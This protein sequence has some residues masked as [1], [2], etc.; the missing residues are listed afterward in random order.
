[1][2]TLDPTRVLNDVSQASVVL[3]ANDKGVKT[4]ALFIK[5]TAKINVE[6][7]LKVTKRAYK[8]PAA[9][10]VKVT[11]ATTDWVAGAYRINIDFKLSSECQRSD[12]ARFKTTKGKTVSIEAFVSV[13]GTLTPIVTSVNNFFKPYEN[14]DFSVASAVE[15]TNTVL[16]FTAGDEFIRVNSITIEKYNGTT[17]LFEAFATGVIT[18]GTEGFG[19]PWHLLKNLRLPTEENLALTALHQDERPIT[20]VQYNQ[21]TIHY[22]VDR[23]NMGYQV[24]GGTAESKASVTLYIPSTGVTAFEG[25]ITTDLGL[26]LAT[27]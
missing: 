15:T 6:N 12:L 1:M 18:R 5:K 3:A 2:F 7:I 23:G 13:A 24:A 4:K 16:N 20:G 14:K 10:T 11:K 22:K 25:Y 17:G 21:Y 8:A 19:T 9:D 26:T 27:I